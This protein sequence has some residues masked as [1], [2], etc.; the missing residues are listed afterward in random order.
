[1]FTQAHQ[2]LEGLLNGCDSF[3]YTTHGSNEVFVWAC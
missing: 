2:Q 3:L 1:V